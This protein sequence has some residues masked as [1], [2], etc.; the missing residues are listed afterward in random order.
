VVELELVNL[1]K[2]FV[3]GFRLGPL[4]LKVSDNEILVIIGLTGSGKTTILN[5]ISGLLEP[6]SG[7]ILVDGIDI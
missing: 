2:K 4:S 6:D 3:G 7:S 5:L 1:T